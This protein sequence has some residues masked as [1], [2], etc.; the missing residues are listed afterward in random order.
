MEEIE[1]N[2]FN[3]NISRYVSTAKAEP[4]VDL[5]KVHEDLVS[6]ESDMQKALK[7]HNGFLEE[8]GLDLLPKGSTEK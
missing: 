3:L 6:I 5:Q 4:K 2:G 8:L 1:K 7:E